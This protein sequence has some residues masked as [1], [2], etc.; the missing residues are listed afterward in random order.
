MREYFISESKYL[1]L[2]ITF[3][4]EKMLEEA[5]SL[6]DKFVQHR[7]GASNGWY[8][9]VLHGLDEHKTGPWKQYGI[10]DPNKA[11]DMMH[12]TLASDLAPITKDYFINHFPCN[13]YSRVR[14]ML[15]EAGGYINY[16]N[17]SKGPI[18][19]NISFV[20][21][22]PEGF[23][24]KWQDGSPDMKMIPGHAYAMNIHYHH[25]LWNNSKED[26]YFVIASR[27]DALPEWKKLMTDAATR[28][29][30]IG[31]FITI[32]SIP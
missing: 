15:L 13:S 1:D 18:I 19:D 5:K 16:H 26:R 10:T 31:E 7:D 3:P 32:D 27:N 12:W 24:W 28:Q 17:D 14:F 9:L 30:V 11:K 6:R 20:L 21:S 2:D 4:H 22:S 23:E 8:G 29:G 25:G